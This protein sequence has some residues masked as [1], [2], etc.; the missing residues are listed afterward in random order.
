MKFIISAKK[1]SFLLKNY[2][3][4]II[5]FLNKVSL[6]LNSSSFSQKLSVVNKLL[7]RHLSSLKILEMWLELFSQPKS[8]IH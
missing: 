6:F 3:S 7:I 2:I 8:R 4:A 5:Y 1:L